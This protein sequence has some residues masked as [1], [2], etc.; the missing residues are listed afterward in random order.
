MTMGLCRSDEYC[1]CMDWKEVLS[2][3]LTMD[4]M[5]I[6]SRAAIESEFHT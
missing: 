3:G 6:C 2:I 4:T 5:M 1:D